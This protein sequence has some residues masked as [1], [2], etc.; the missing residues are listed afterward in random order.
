MDEYAA[1][2]ICSIYV[3]DRM[4]RGCHGTGCYSQSDGDGRIDIINMYHYMHSQD[5]YLGSKTKKC[6][7]GVKKIFM[8]IIQS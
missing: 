4:Y 5:D 6:R 8:R 1:D 7:K 3:L 2:D